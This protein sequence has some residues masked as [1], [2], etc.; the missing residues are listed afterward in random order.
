MKS[1]FLLGGRERAEKTSV[2]EVDKGEMAVFLIS[3]VLKQR[4]G[5]Q[6]SSKG[7]FL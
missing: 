3:F 7:W 5:E 6:R 2:K 4:V 1:L